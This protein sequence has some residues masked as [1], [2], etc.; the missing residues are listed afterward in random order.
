MFLFGFC[1]NQSLPISGHDGQTS[2][3][4][5]G[6]SGTGSVNNQQLCPTTFPCSWPEK[7]ACCRCN[8][9]DEAIKSGLN[10]LY[11]FNRS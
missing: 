8:Q 11:L 5:G 10:C 6:G 3:S 7:K 9:N 1:I 4:G 2:G